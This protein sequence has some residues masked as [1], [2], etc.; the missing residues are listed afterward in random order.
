MQKVEFLKDWKG[1]RTG[2][3]SYAY[4]ETAAVWKRMGLVKFINDSRDKMQRPVKAKKRG[5]PKK[6]APKKTV[7]SPSQ[8][9]AVLVT[10]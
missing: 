5:R 9:A 4:P 10:E 1:S 3:T 2:Q 8:E 6:K 7:E